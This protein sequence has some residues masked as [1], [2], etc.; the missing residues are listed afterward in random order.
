MLEVAYREAEEVLLDRTVFHLDPE[1]FDRFNAMLDEPTPPSE[2]VRKLMQ[3][4]PPW[5]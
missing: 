4:K 5:E 1:T 2:E 3:L